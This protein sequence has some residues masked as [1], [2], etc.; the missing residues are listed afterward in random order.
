MKPLTVHPEVGPWARLDFRFSISRS[1]VGHS[2][3]PEPAKLSA[4][5]AVTARALLTNFFMRN[6]LQ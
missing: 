1:S 2:S 6:A 3:V 4:E 5:T